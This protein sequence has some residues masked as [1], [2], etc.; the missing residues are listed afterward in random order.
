MIDI[1]IGK[2]RDRLNLQQPI[3]LS[4]GAGGFTTN[5]SDTAF[6]WAE[7][8]SLTGRESFYADQYSSKLTHEITIWYK[9]NVKP[10]MRFVKGNRVFQIVSVINIEQRNQWLKCLCEEREV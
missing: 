7:I 5:W 6:V 9:D 10:K 3:T 1:E 2:L 8:K 4:D